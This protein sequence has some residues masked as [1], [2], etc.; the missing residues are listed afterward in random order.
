MTY[1]I[2]YA[3]SQ[4]RGELLLRT[5]FGLIY[6]YIP[7]AFILFFLGLWGAILGFISFWIILFTGRYP[8]SFFEYQ[9][10]LI[11]WQARLSA[12]QLN[13]IDGYP[14]FGLDSVDEK[15]IVDIPYPEKLSR[16]ML[17]VKAFFGWLYVAI[18]HGFVL[19]FLALG[20]YV[21]L[22]LGWWIIL[23]TGKLPVG[24]HNYLV[25]VLRWGQRVNLYMANMTDEYPPFSLS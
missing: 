1:D 3:E 16:G 6:M 23:F 14:A 10:K 11:R 21:V 18:P 20:A 2:K 8:Q 13:L 22:F 7:H 5:F 12:R 24:F 19:F 9:V 25:G 15:V 4:S 17:L